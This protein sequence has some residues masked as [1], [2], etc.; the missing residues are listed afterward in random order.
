M[1]RNLVCI[2]TMTQ[3]FVFVVQ[4]ELLFAQKGNQLLLGI[5]FVVGSVTYVA[6]NSHD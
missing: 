1:L 4:C 6:F 3:H 5:C 2:N